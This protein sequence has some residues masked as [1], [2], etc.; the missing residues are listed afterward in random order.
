MKRY[1]VLLI[2]TSFFLCFV[3]Q[4]AGAQTPTPSPEK[5]EKK[6][7][8][9][10][11][12]DKIKYDSQNEQFV[13]SGNVIA[14]QGKNRIQC[15]DLSF[16]LKDNQGTFTGGV[17][18]ARDKTT[19]RS[20][21]MDGDFD[22]DRYTFDGEVELKKERQEKEGTSTILWKAQKLAYNGNTEEAQSE[23][24]VEITWKQTTIKAQKASYFP[25]D[26]ARNQLERIELD[27]Q[28]FITEKEREIEVN[29]AVYYLD[30][31]TLEAETI[32]RARFILG[33]KK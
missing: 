26:E 30:T 23:E 29:R 32:I 12:A 27:G 20:T 17:A 5:K 31:E 22:Q 16:S 11:K 33:E 3:F 21:S 14:V 4:F 15:Q 25:K 9:L 10:E 13:A 8:L 7:V 24:G 18:V 28:V 19:I 2:I 6:E 1:S